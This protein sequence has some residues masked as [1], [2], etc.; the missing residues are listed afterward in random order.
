M[1]DNDSWIGRIEPGEDPFGGPPTDETGYRA[2][3][4]GQPGAALGFDL[5]PADPTV[6][7]LTIPYYQPI[8]MRRIEQYG[9]LSLICPS[10]ELV[11]HIEGRQVGKIA[12]ALSQRRVIALHEYGEATHGPLDEGADVVI[13]NIKTERIG[14]ATDVHHPA[15]AQR[16][17]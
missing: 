3:R 1:D 12:E 6:F 15:G 5:V 17:I 16:P 7:T 11:V 2:I 8:T 13:S 9:L 14:N 10:S 4:V